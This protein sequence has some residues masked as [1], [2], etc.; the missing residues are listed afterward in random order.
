MNDALA[1]GVNV[2]FPSQA[3]GLP[4]SLLKPN[5]NFIDHG[6]HIGGDIEVDSKTLGEI[7]GAK[8]IKADQCKPKKAT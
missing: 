4:I 6:V 5:I 7:V 2:H 1:K 3:T 8:G